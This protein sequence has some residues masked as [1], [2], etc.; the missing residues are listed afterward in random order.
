[1]A[2]GAHCFYF[3]L[4]FSA[5]AHPLVGGPSRDPSN[6]SPAPSLIGG[7]VTVAPSAGGWTLVRWQAQWLCMLYGVSVLLCVSGMVNS[8]GANY[9]GDVVP[10]SVAQVIPVLRRCLEFPVDRLRE[11]SARD[12]CVFWVSCKLGNLV[13]ECLYGGVVLY[14]PAYKL[15]T[16]CFDH[17]VGVCPPRYGCDW[18][19]RLEGPSL[20]VSGCAGGP[21][22][23]DGDCGVEQVAF[24]WVW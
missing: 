9:V 22:V 16:G 20:A 4:K 11:C 13:H 15:D 21:V 19:F 10:V 1:M 3:Y 2:G 12:V 17:A 18:T 5:S 6:S 7:P 23:C 14:G 8:A 24:L